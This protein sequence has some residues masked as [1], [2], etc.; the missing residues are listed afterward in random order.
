MRR[1]W[2][3]MKDIMRSQPDGAPMVVPLPEMFHLA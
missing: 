2:D 1:W 3:Y